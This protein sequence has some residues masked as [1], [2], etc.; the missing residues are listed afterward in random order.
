MRTPVSIFLHSRIPQFEKMRTPVF[1][2][3]ST[4][5]D[6]GEELAVPVG[7]LFVRLPLE[8]GASTEQPL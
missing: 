2:S 3:F 6:M 5:L 8:G 1:H 7:T 4:L